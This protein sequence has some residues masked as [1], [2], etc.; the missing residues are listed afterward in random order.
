MVTE[1]TP[2]RRRFA[3]I[4]ATTDR[5]PT[6]WFAAIGTGV[7]LA[8]TAAFGGLATAAEEPVPSAA[9]E[10]EVIAKPFTVSVE[11]AVLIDEFPEA[12]I[13]VEDGQRVLALQLEVVNTWTEPLAA[14][15]KDS[16]AGAVRVQ[17][18]D[19]AEST[20]RYD[21]ATGNPRLQPGVPAEIVLTWAIDPEEFSEGDEIVVTVN[22]MSLHVGSF[23]A[24]G[25]WWTDPVP[26]A[27]VTVVA[28]D[29]GSGVAQ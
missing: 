27:E 12:G 18:L 4:R 22:S 13:Y 28:E 16:L 19:L 23:V 14:G 20:A 10:Q 21:D 7:F 11:R 9:P 25:Q 8:A 2:A 1:E 6:K 5:V 3:W 15:S 17:G 29:V 26:A 24:S